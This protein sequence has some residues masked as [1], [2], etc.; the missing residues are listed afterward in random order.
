MHTK[1]MTLDDTDTA[2]KIL[3]ELNPV[4]QKRLGG[5]VAGF[6]KT[7]WDEQVETVLLQGL[8]AKFSQNDNCKK[9]LKNT[10][11]RLI[12]EATKDK[13]F[14]VGMDLRNNQLLNTNKWPPQGNLMGKCLMTVRAEL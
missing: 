2:N 13:Q 10:D 8:R 9:F 12:G 11:S 14:G 6:E 1:A 3:K 5:K 7:K 4:E